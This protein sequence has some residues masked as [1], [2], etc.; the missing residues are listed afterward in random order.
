MGRPWALLSTQKQNKPI[1]KTA[2]YAVAGDEKKSDVFCLPDRGVCD[3]SV[4]V[5]PRAVC[6]DYFYGNTYKCIYVHSI[7]I[8]YGIDIN[9]KYLTCLLHYI[10]I[11]IVCVISV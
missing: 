8:W 4:Y 9:I 7:C 2:D 10:Y 1:Q 11:Y 3:R 6:G 5:K